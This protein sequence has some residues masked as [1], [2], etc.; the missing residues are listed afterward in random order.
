M[1]DWDIIA[2]VLR[3]V[4]SISGKSLHSARFSEIW[5][6]PGWK[7][8][9]R[10]PIIRLV[11]VYLFFLLIELI[12]SGEWFSLNLGLLNKVTIMNKGLISIIVLTLSRLQ[13]ICL[14]RY[15]FKGRFIVQIYNVISKTYLYIW[16]SSVWKCHNFVARRM[17]YWFSWRWITSVWFFKHFLI[18]SLRALAS[19]IPILFGLFFKNRFFMSFD[20]LIIKA[21]LI[22]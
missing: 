20:W 11:S 9:I 1:I 5:M 2:I 14:T 18:L 3:P 4:R 19:I 17:L 7:R 16:C 15:L 10:G 22:L 6:F 12:H 21:D 8:L 13:N